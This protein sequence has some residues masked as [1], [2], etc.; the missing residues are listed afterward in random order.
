MTNRSYLS[1]IGVFLFFALLSVACTN[2]ATMS[3]AT[4]W[5]SFNSPT[6]GYF[7]MDYPSDWQSD[8]F[9]GGYRGDDEAI[10]LF[11]ATDALFPAVR[12]ARR[13]FLA[14]TLEEVAAWGEAR[15]MA[16]NPDSDD[17]YE[18]FP[19]LEETIP[20][21]EVLS[22][23]YMI[24]LETPLPLMKKDI[25]IA[26][27]QDGIILT[28]T[29]VRDRYEDEKAILEHMVASLRLLDTGSTNAP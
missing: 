25:Y 10:A 17:Q 24:D 6:I 29:T 14:P 26:R 7:A 28:F 22:R 1:G 16:L 13:E 15:I 5:R 20:A 2:R 21:G 4:T 12:I 19:L 9:P 18:L 23:E 8:R 11:Y 3:G 27:E